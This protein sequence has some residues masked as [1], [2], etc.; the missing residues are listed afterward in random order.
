MLIAFYIGISAFFYVFPQILH[1]KRAK[2]KGWN[3]AIIGHRGG[4]G[5]QCQNT[6]EAFEK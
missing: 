4:G 5:E 2:R 1:K 6:L 3:F